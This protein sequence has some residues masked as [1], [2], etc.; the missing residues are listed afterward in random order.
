MSAARVLRQ[1][2]E[3]GHGLSFVAGL[4]RGLKENKPYGFLRDWHDQHGPLLKINMLVIKSVSIVDAQVV[5]WVTRN[6]PARFTKGSGYESI[7]R[8]WLDNSLV[9]SE[10]EEWRRKRS[11]YNR[12]FKLSA[13]RSYVPLFIEIAEAAASK[14]KQ[15]HEKQEVIDA[16]RSFESV[17]LEA[18]GQAGFGV[19]GMGQDGNKY[20]NAFVRYLDVLQD[21][22]TSPAM[23]LLPKPLKHFITRVRGGTH[24]STMNDESRRI[25]S[26]KPTV[27][28]P[29]GRNLVSLI[30]EAA[31]EEQSS[32]DA[33]QL[34]REAN[35]FLFAGHDTTSASLAWAFAL[36]AEHPESQ[37]RLHEELTAALSSSSGCSEAEL[38]A[39][40][41][42]DPRALPFMGAVI[43]ETLR[44]CPPAP[45]VMRRTKFDEELGGYE[46]P[47]GTDLSLNIWCMQRDPAVF[48][49]PDVFKPDRWLTTD[50]EKLKRMQ[51]HWAPFMV[52]ARSCIGQQFSMMEMRVVIATLVRRFTVELAS[53]PQVRQ[54]MLLLPSKVL[55]R[56]TPR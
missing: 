27:S 29:A 35:L 4:T 15:H 41:V 50:A 51:D 53:Q 36:L 43:R 20:A 22:I 52:G 28:S 8:G 42:S 26:S 7:Q 16:V 45:M 17:A 47:A 38:L 56:C 14:W 11:V 40:Q 25:S 37:T 6:D 30:R 48:E 54:R 31:A 46:V 2:P 34:A 10:D 18:I 39:E 49:E 32:I 44:L 5:K 1:L 21:E 13:I 12:A 24:L 33:E 23:M 19:R 3:P 55:L 9:L